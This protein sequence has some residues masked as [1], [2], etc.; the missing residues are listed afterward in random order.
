MYGQLGIGKDKYSDPGKLVSSHSP[1]KCT[2]DN[3]NSVVCGLDNSVFATG[4]CI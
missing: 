2:T 1:V 4:L 3:I